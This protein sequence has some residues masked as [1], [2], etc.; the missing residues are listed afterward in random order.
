MDARAKTVRE[1]LNSS[2]QY[3]IPFFQRSYSWKPQHWKRLRDDIWAL[4]E[5]GAESQHFLGPLV[6]TPLKNLPAEVQSYQLIDGQQRLTTLTIILAVLRDV[7]KENGE[8]ELA[9]R[10]QEAYLLH[11]WEK[12]LRRYKVV[13]RLGDREALIAIVEGTPTDA[14]GKLNLLRARRFFY[15]QIVEWASNS[16]E[17][18]LNLLL[19]SVIG[20]L[21]L[22]VITID[23]ENP[24]E[25]FESLN[26]TGLPLEESD[27]IRNYI[28]M[29]VSTA[30]QEEFHRTHW[31]P[32]ETVFDECGEM[33]AIPPT[34]FYRNYLMR[35]GEY[36]K[37]RATFVGFKEENRKRQIST[38]E[39]VAELKR[40]S[41][42]ELML[43]RPQSCE[44]KA[45][46]ESLE[47]VSEL[48][49]TTAHPLL[50][51]LLDRHER[52]ELDEADLLECLADLSS[53]VLRRSI[54]G[55]STRAYG[56]W[57][58]EAVKSIADKPREDLRSYWLRRGWPDDKT[59]IARLQD[60]ALYRR[61]PKK[62]RMILQALERS[63]G[64]KEKVDPNT[65]TVEHVMPQTIKSGKSAAAW[66]AMLGEQWSAVHDTWLHT[67][68]N[69]TLS[70]YNPNLSNKPYDVKQIELA[71]SNLV[72]NRYFKKVKAW[73]EAGIQKRG[74]ALAEE[75]AALWPRPTEGPAYIPPSVVKPEVVTCE[76][77]RKR[78]QE[79]WSGL[80]ALLQARG[81]IKRLPKASTSGSLHLSMGT[82]AFRLI[83]FA[84]PK[85]KWA[86]VALICRGK[87]GRTNFEA[88]RSERATIEAEVGEGLIWQEMP[89]GKTFHISLRRLHTDS[90]DRGNWPEQH[91]WLAEK[92]E[93]LYKVFS[94]RCEDLVPTKPEIRR[95]DR[96]EY[97]TVFTEYVREHT[98]QSRFPRST[99]GASVKMPL[100]AT[101]TKVALFR[102]EGKGMIGVRVT[103][104]D[105][106]IDWLKNERSEVEQRLG[107]DV[108]VRNRMKQPMIA[109]RREAA[110][111][112]E[113]DWPNQFEWFIKIVRKLEKVLGPRLEEFQNQ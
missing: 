82:A 59:F 45:L 58:P 100:G 62:C 36:S 11:K 61:E 74:T 102:Y 56:R 68:G 77:R 8:D 98:S 7:A 51:V 34:A 50:M 69:L 31:E 90:R 9:A 43:R 10:I 29:Q 19:K 63:Y 65:L 66:K 12:G 60:F 88:L 20:Q 71:K 46:R 84:N 95:P 57:F 18:K 111:E 52:G 93:L 54:C 28:F 109:V 1:I 110:V 41:A 24:Y 103:K 47:Q 55:E 89:S 85:R 5:D 14:Y 27:L 91:T 44:S 113:A 94:K 38:V 53:F 79:Y 72:L 81:V 112:N 49:I 16:P 21:S 99:D 76:E 37:A 83:T 92:A 33:P 70:G 101:G 4:M 17:E 108:F 2:D 6:C 48:E 15:K 96:L 42:H 73:N 87:K 3:V 97:W 78:R 22:V 80:V 39:Q 30:E 13:P 32:F 64:H 35:H 67:L 40:F 106:F 23:G 26:S 75:V 107:K 105:G 104:P 86:G 25:I